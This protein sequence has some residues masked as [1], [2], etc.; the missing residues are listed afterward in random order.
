MK[1]RGFQISWWLVLV[2]FALI[3]GV[4]LFYEQIKQ[5]LNIPDSVIEILIQLLTLIPVFIGLRVLKREYPYTK[6]REL[7]GIRGFDITML[8][9]FAVM[10]LAMQFFATYA[11]FFVNAG[12]IGLFGEYDPGIAQPDTLK[13]LAFL[14]LTACVAAPVLEELLF[15]GVMMKLLEPYGFLTAAIVSG[16]A[17]SMLH[18][19]PAGFI[20]IAFIGFILAYIRYVSGSVIACMV[21]HGFS[22][23]YSVINIVFQNEIMRFEKQYMILS[24]VFA[25]LFPVIILIYKKVYPQHKRYIPIAKRLGFSVGLF[26]CVCIYIGSCIT[27]LLPR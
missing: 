24:I 18:M 27:M 13:E 2:E 20:I 11:A 15:R 25:V 1:Y 23:F 16:I 22:N 14:I 7:L 3:F 17:F 5:F 12:L 21:L 9:F 8:L 19:Q 6:Y 10:P 4:S 26:I